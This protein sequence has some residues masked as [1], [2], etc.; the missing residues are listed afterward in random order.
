MRAKLWKALSVGVCALAAQAGSATVVWSYDGGSPSSTFPISLNVTGG[1]KVLRVY[2]TTGT[3]AIGA[4]EVSGTVASGSSLCIIVA[5]P[6]TPCIDGDSVTCGASFGG[7]SFG[8]TSDDLRNAS[9]CNDID[10]NNDGLFPDTL[11]ID[12]Y[13]SVFSG[14]PCLW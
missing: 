10:F 8:P 7:L 14:G 5:S 9:R 2:S 13:L 4:V 11:D 6:G 3:E 1:D 12:A